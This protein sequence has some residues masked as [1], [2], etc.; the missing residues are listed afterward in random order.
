MRDYDAAFDAGAEKE[1]M[2]RADYDEMMAN[3]PDDDDEGYR[4]F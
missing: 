1:Y 2:D 4:Q 3:A